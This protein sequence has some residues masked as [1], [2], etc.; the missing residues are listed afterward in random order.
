M[1]KRYTIREFRHPRGDRRIIV[2]QHAD[3]RFGFREERLFEASGTRVWGGL[4]N[5]PLLFD[6]EDGAAEQAWLS[7][8]WLREC[9]PPPGFP[10][11]PQATPE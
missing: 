9:T 7:I 2:F 10:H 3:G 11:I 8:P 6:T 5:Q 1:V 4:W